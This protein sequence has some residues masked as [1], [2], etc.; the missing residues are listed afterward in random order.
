VCLNLSAQW[1]SVRQLWAEQ[2]G[3]SQVEADEAPREDGRR[4]ESVFAVEGVEKRQVTLARQVLARYLP[5]F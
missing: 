4:A 1:R 2:G 5:I 3:H